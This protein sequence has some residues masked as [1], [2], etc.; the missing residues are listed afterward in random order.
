MFSV[1]ADLMRA[2]FAAFSDGTRHIEAADARQASVVAQDKADLARR[3]AWAAIRAAR[4]E[5]QR[6]E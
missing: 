3:K 1:V 6:G 4:E 5:R 2:L